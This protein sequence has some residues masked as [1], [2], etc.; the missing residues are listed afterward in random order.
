MDAP[1]TVCDFFTWYM[2]RLRIHQLQFWSKPFVIFSETSLNIILWKRTIN[3]KRWCDC[4][5]RLSRGYRLR[6]MITIKSSCCASCCGGGVWVAW[7]RWCWGLA[8]SPFIAGGPSDLLR[9]DGLEA[10]NADLSS[11]CKQTNTSSCEVPAVMS[12]FQ[13][14]CWSRY[15]IRQARE[16]HSL[17]NDT[18]R[19]YWCWYLLF[20]IARIFFKVHRQTLMF[21]YSFDSPSMTKH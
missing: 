15:R 3:Q 7:R 21:K 19:I 8:E 11:D 2:L 12:K 6:T 14:P 13:Y 1:Y 4:R 20:R 5:A 10:P 9:R 17:R 18:A 16:L